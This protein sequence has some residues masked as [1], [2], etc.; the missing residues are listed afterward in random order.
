[1]RKV[2]GQKSKI[3]TSSDLKTIVAARKRALK[4]FHSDML[5]HQL[6]VLFAIGTRHYAVLQ[7]HCRVVDV[8]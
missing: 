4:S 3:L 8:V 7:I 2:S 1:M 6:N 5:P